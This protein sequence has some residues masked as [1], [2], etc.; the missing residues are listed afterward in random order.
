MERKARTNPPQLNGLDDKTISPA[1][2]SRRGRIVIGIILEREE[3]L[4]C[5]AVE[6]ALRLVV[7][8]ER[9]GIEMAAT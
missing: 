1:P 6:G 5:G 3:V 8:T 2:S 9:G 4:I 7:G